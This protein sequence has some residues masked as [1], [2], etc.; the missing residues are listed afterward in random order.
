MKIGIT[1]LI[2]VTA[3]VVLGIGAW[4]AFYVGRKH[5]TQ[6]AGWSA[7]TQPAA[8]RRR[9]HAVRH[10]RGRRRAR[11]PCGDR[12]RVGTVRLLVR[13]VRR[14]LDVIIAAF[15]K[16]LRKGRFSTIPEILRPT[17]RR[18]QDAPHGRRDRRH[19]RPLRMARNAVRRLRQSLQRGH[20]HR[21]HS[22]HHHHGDREPPVRPARRAHLR[23]M[24]RLLLRR[25]HDRHLDRR[26]DLRSR[27]RW[28]H[29]PDPDERA[30]RL[31]HDAAR[32]HPRGAWARSSSGSSRSFPAPSRTSST[33]SASSPRRTAGKP[34]SR[35]TWARSWCSS[36]ACTRTSSASRSGL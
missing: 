26:R 17:V 32:P 35:C 15:A 28:G 27:E 1:S 14:R 7:A 23:G 13:A 31:L 24:V 36:P 33:T 11:R 34:A 19:R 22:A 8:L 12:L 21:V 6:D 16:W 18:E 20:G 25:L 9:L 2:S 4:I 29:R 5:S 10:R 30:G 3:L